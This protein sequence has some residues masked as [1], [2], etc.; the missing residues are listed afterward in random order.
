MSFSGACGKGHAAGWVARGN[1]QLQLAQPLAALASY[2]AAVKVGPRHTLGWRNMGVVLREL[3]RTRESAEA[4][5]RA[6]DLEKQH[7]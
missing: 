1:A 5:S 4:L 6:L 2:Q 7:P 3:G